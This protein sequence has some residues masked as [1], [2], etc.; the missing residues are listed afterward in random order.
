MFIEILSIINLSLLD[1]NECLSNETNNCSHYCL[2]SIGSYSCYC[3][4]GYELANDCFT[5]VG[6]C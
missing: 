2:D 6:R 3:Y 4:V 1:I 5:C